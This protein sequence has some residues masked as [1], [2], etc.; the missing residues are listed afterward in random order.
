M[1]NKA[2]LITYKII[3][4]PVP[5]ANVHTHMYTY[6]KGVLMS[7]QLIQAASQV[8][9]IPCCD[10]RT[11]FQHEKCLFLKLGKQLCVSRWPM[12]GPVPQLSPTGL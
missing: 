1:F 10:S 11:R 12:P 6:T 3:F 5:F 4:I 2:R 7:I 9:H 8:E